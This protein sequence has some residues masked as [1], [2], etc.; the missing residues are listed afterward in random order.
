M[1]QRFLALAVSVAASLA[2]TTAAMA[3]TIDTITFNNA[4]GVAYGNVYVGIY[5]GT[6][7]NGSTTTITDFICDDFNHEIGSGDFWNAYVGSTNPISSMLRFGPTDIVDPELSGLTQQEDY[8]MVTYLAEQIFADP[9]NS[10]GNWGYLA[11]AIWSINSSKAYESPY[12]NSEVNEFVT[13]A[14]AYKDTNNGNLIV[15]TPTG[16]LGQEFLARDPNPTP[17]PAS[18]VLFGTSVA[19]ALAWLGGK[20]LLS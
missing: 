1:K 2:L 7:F 15:Y 20:K 10:N 3:G 19:L 11:W 5:Q 9:D 13:D 14:L 12:Y 6:V 8:N 4:T 18:V 16:D 17:E